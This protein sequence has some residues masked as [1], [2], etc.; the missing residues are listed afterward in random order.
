MGVSKTTFGGFARFSK[1]AGRM[2]GVQDRLLAVVDIWQLTRP[3]ADG[4]SRSL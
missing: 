2:K 4:M 3:C 1:A